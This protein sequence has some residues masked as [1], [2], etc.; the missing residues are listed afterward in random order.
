MTDRLLA[1]PV[2]TV[3]DITR[4]RSVTAHRHRE[5]QPQVNQPEQDTIPGTGSGD[6]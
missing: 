4:V 1:V 3:L 2:G 6:Q 5:E